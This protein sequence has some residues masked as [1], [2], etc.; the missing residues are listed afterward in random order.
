MEGLKRHLLSVLNTF[1][2]IMCSYEENSGEYTIR[3]SE[4]KEN[5]IGYKITISKEEL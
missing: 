1:Y 4:T 5:G 3:I 2:N